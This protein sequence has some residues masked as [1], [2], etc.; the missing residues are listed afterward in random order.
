MIACKT[1]QPLSP[2]KI[3]E[4]LTKERSEE[5]K[6][7]NQIE[8]DEQQ[9]DSDLGNEDEDETRAGEEFVDKLNESEKSLSDNFGIP[10][11]HSE[12]TS[13]DDAS[14]IQDLF[15]YVLQTASKRPGP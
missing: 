12:V 1:G 10:K 15:G 11:T 8:N 2:E 3:E 7:A 5:D 9:F 14:K 13:I 4:I 6:V